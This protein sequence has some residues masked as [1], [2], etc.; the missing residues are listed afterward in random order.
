[1][2]PFHRY[3]KGLS[4]W[5]VVLVMVIV[6]V[7][8]ALASPSVRMGI[9]N[10]QA[11]QA[12][13]TLKSIH[14]AVRMYEVDHGCLPGA[15]SCIPPPPGNKTALQILQDTGYLSS[16]EYP[17]LRTGSADPNGYEYKALPNGSA[18]NTWAQARRYT[19]TTTSGG[20]GGCGCND[21]P[22]TTTTNPI[23][24]VQIC[25]DQ[26]K[27]RD[28]LGSSEN[29]EGLLSTIGTSQCPAS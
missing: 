25:R 4:L 6:G 28:V 14:H 5:E 17:Y 8:A 9:E 1:M 19:T 11:K 12:L 22:P 18:N 3:K 20:G 24:T 27:I 2:Y 15:A 23:R 26:T 13:E 21:D 16:A 10:R 7:A 29:Q